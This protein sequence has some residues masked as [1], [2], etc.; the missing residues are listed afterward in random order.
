MSHSLAGEWDLRIKTPIGSLDVVY[1]FTESTEGVAGSA[2]SASETVPLTDIVDRDAADGRHV[3]WR[4]KVTRPM[5]LNLDFDVV[6]TGDDLRGQARAG[7][8]PGSAV[9]GRRRT[10]A[11]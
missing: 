10:G 8:L 1:T 3:T 11:R 2:R 7:R 5:R 6:V 4:Q 9:T